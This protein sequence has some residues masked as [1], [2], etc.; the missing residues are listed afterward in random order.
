[1]KAATHSL[2]HD[3]EVRE[4]ASGAIMPDSFTCMPAGFLV[5]ASALVRADTHLSAR[6]LKWAALS[7]TDQ[8]VSA[9][10]RD[11]VRLSCPVT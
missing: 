9:S 7:T 2:I 10:S 1:M 8:Q 3:T 4:L 6:A 5:M 11:R